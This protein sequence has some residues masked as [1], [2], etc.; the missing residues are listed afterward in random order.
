MAME[1]GGK[2]WGG[3]EMKYSS[4]SGMVYTLQSDVE[5]A[6]NYQMI[7]HNSFRHV[8]TASEIK[9]YPDAHIGCRVLQ[10]HAPGHKWVHTSLYDT[11]SMFK[12]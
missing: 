1:Q 8:L 10:N 2:G 5:F 4:I 9:D 12:K 3:G 7:P 6:F 11:Y